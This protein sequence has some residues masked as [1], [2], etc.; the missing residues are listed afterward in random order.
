MVV[1][2]GDTVIVIVIYCLF[3]SHCAWGGFDTVFVLLRFAASDLV[4]HG[5]S[6]SHKRTLG[7]YGLM[8][9]FILSLHCFHIHR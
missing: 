9:P 3:W 5:L 7:L 8:Y 2:C 1:A 6:M 4:L